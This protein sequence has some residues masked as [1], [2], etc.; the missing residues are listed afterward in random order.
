MLTGSQHSHVR[1]DCVHE[2][3]ASLRASA[4]KATGLEFDFH[5][6]TNFLGT[7]GLFLFCQFIIVN[8]ISLV[9][10]FSAFCSPLTSVHCNTFLLF[11]AN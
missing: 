11:G 6:H 7:F 8:R 1:L 9:L 10:D 2:G 4:G 3:G 5:D